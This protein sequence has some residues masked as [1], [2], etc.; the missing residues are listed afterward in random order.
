MKNLRFSIKVNCIEKMARLEERL[1]ARRHYFQSIFTH[2]GLSGQYKSKGGILNVPVTVDT[3]V[4]SLLGSLDDTN[5]MHVIL[6][7]RLSFRKD[8]IKGN[9][10]A[11]LVREVTRY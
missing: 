9:I 8:Y 3:T 1:V 7:R 11:N 5:A 4:S 2:K 6:A 10:D